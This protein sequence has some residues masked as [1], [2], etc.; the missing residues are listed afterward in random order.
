MITINRNQ[1][2]MQRHV[3]MVIRIPSLTIGKSL[4]E[5]LH[6]RKTSSLYLNSLVALHI[7]KKKSIYKVQPLNIY[8]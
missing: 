4:W 3:T 1:T 8:F 2:D 6:L 5:S 7:H